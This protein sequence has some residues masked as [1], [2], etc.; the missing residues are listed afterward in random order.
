MS[1]CCL[2]FLFFPVSRK[3]S[4]AISCKADVSYFWNQ[5]RLDLLISQDLD[6]GKG[7]LSFSGISYISGKPESYLNKTISF[8]Y[9]QHKEFYTFRF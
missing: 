5:E 1:L 4:F 9:L 6:H 7:V 3:E 8:L 2:Y